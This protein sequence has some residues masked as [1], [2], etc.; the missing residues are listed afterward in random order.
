MRNLPQFQGIALKKRFGQNFLQDA[1]Y[2]D[3]M[4][5]QVELTA[6]TSVLEIGGGA[7]VLTRAILAQKP[8]RLWVFEIDPEWV[9]YLGKQIKDKRLTVIADNILDFDFEQFAPHAPWTILANLPYHITFPLL[10][11]IQQHRTLFAQGVIMVQDEVAQKITKTHGRDY[12]F[13][14]LF[15]QWYFQW[16]LLDRVPPSAFFPAPKVFSRLLYFKP[17]EKTP[18][19]PDEKLFWQFIKQ[20]FKQPRRT[21]RNNLAQGSYDTT[22]IP[23]AIVLL[24]AQ[25]LSMADLLELWQMVRR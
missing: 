17:I 20:C 21:L 14:S 22:N 7:G 15:F 11:R 18:E 6:G 13:I 3:V 2:L 5:Q 25:Q 1:R 8:A 4:P 23:E 16:R 24:R 9:A 12:G 10:H 19:I